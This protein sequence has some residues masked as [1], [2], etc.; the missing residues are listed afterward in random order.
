QSNSSVIIDH[1]IML[2]LFRLV[3]PGQ[4]PEAEMTRT[5]TARGFRNAPALLGEIVHVPDQGEEEVLGVVQAFIPGEGD[6]WEWTL[7]YLG[8]VLDEMTHE[9]VD[10]DDL[11]AIYENFVT[12]LGQR[13]ADMHGILAQPSDDE[14]FAPA[15]ADARQLERW[16]ARIAGRVTAALDA[17]GR[18]GESLSEADRSLA[19][20]LLARR[21]PLLKAVGEL[22][23]SGKGSLLHR[24]HGDFHLGQTLVASGDIM[25]IDFEGEPAQ[26]LAER[27]AKDSGWRDVAGILRSLDYALAAARNLSGAALQD[28]R[29]ERLAAAFRARMPAALLAAYRQS[30]AAAGRGEAAQSADERLLA[31]FMIEKAAYEV[32]YEVGNRPDWLS[33]PLRGLAE[34]AARLLDE[35]DR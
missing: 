20:G 13:L 35:D 2:K 34:L 27:R 28:G 10:L 11:L 1:K 4:H 24:V 16:A 30:L 31:L 14:A 6:A 12:T 23:K 21:K 3:A 5:L 32:T 29:Y 19:D 17:L 9:E 22:A 8:R 15:I 18:Q 33:V 26:P 7:A 25:L